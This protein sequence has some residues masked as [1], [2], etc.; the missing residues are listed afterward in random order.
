MDGVETCQILEE[1]DGFNCN[2]L[3]SA[4]V[5]DRVMKVPRGYAIGLMTADG[6]LGHKQE[7]GAAC[8]PFKQVLRRSVVGTLWTDSLIERHRGRVFPSRVGTCRVVDGGASA[9][10]PRLF[11]LSSTLAAFFLSH[12][13]ALCPPWR[14]DRPGSTRPARRLRRRRSCRPDP[15]SLNP[16]AKRSFDR[17]AIQQ[18]VAARRA[19]FLLAAAKRRMGRI[20]GGGP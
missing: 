16:Q 7:E 19:Q 11:G 6:G 14:F 12:L 10:T 15:E 18:P 2:G 20:P 3:A 1:Q 17:K 13:T 5:I 9:S 8:R 4:G